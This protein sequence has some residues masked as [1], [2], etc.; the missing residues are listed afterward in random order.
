MIKDKKIPAV[1]LSGGSEIVSLA[2]AEA[3]ATQEIPLVVISLVKSSL[4][5]DIP[6]VLHYRQIQWPPETAES[7]VDELRAILINMGAGN[8]QPWPVFATEDGGLRLLLEK[9]EELDKYLAISPG[10]THL[11]MGGLDKAELFQFLSSMG[12]G[13]VIA[14]TIVLDTM[15]TVG[16]VLKEFHGEAIFKP[17]LKPLSM[18]LD[19]PGAKVV[20]KRKG[21][22][23]NLW[24]KRLQKAWPAS[25]QWI[26]QP[27]LHTPL[28]GEALWWGIRTKRGN[29]TGIT[30]YERWKQPRVGGS[31]CL[32]DIHNIQEVK[33][34]AEKILVGLDFV[35]VAELPFLQDSNGNWRLLELNI[36]PWLQVGITPIADFPVLYM[37]YKELLG[38]KAAERAPSLLSSKRWVNVERMVLAAL[39]GEYGPR[40]G[41]LLRV[42]QLVY[43]SD[44]KAVYSTP[45]QGVRVRWLRRMIQKTVG[46]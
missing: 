33:L 40:L 31:A 16:H 12:L 35:G 43:G 26:A 42:V 39:S 21:G 9:R 46:G 41:A 34:L 4:I 7:A 15:D 1:I 10:S 29:M 3:L 19:V 14:P 30:S 20:H 11:R 38:I 6:P 2:V 22:D 24:R 37:L 44:Y 36:R 17:A 28:E 5:R 23:E 8:P 45:F 25:S 32:V 27:F 13:D 18:S